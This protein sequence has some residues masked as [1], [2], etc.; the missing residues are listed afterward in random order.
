MDVS[1]FQNRQPGMFILQKCCRDESR[2]GVILPV[3]SH[4]ALYRTSLLI[5]RGCRLL[6]RVRRVLCDCSTWTS[7]MNSPDKEFG[8]PPANP[9][10]EGATTPGEQGGRGPGTVAVRRTPVTAL[11]P[12]SPGRGRSLAPLFGSPGRLPAGWRA[13]RWLGSA[14]CPR[15]FSSWRN[16]HGWIEVFC[17]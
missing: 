13:G 5:D 11:P 3:G 2:D 8:R 15:R 4:H 12:A 14:S 10:G 17:I 16:S 1:L 9:T 7:C 6:W